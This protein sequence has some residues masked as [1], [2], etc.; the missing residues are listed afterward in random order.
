MIYEA[1][2]FH[3]MKLDIAD[4]ANEERF[5]PRLSTGFHEIFVRIGG[6]N[7]E[8]DELSVLGENELFWPSGN[9]E[10]VELKLPSTVL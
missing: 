7:A 2:L 6:T 1:K 8:L 3:E 4:F 5:K 10:T 9:L